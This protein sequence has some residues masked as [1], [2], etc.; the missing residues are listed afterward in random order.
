MS[1]DPTSSPAPE[2]PPTHPEEMKAVFDMKVGRFVTMQCSMRC[3]PADIITAGIAASAIL[4]ACA[5]L[6]RACRR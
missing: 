5:A 4:L 6:V 2:P 3:T 1:S